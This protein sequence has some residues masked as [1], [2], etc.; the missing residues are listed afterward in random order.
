MNRAVFLDRDGTLGGSGGF[1]HPAT[2]TLYAAAINAI[3]LIND[4]GLLAIVIT[5]QHRIAKGEVTAAEFEASFRRHRRELADRGAHLDGWYVCPHE[6]DDGCNCR[7][8]RIGLL[9]Q[10]AQD[11]D[12][13]LAE[14][15]FVG[16]NGSVDLV[17]GAAAGC[18]TVLVR[19]GWGEGSLREFR[20]LW[21][22]VEPD[23]VADTVYEAA[24]FIA[25]H[26]ASH[27]ANPS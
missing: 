9:E 6:R 25:E 23:Y 11:Y 2:F 4:S 13:T 17:A 20:H 12:V 10:A 15:W 7:K 3:K 26:A 1:D 8:P 16:D 5:N 18:G 19:T 27:F 22:H 21:A 24:V 14:S